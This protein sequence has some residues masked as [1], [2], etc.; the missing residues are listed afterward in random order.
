MVGVGVASV[1]APG[2]DVGA[3]AAMLGRLV[4]LRERHEKVLRADRG[5]DAV[6]WMAIDARVKAVQDTPLDRISPVEMD[7]LRTAMD[8]WTRRRAR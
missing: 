8:E 4:L 6:E 5:V 1:I 7:A 3:V 2:S